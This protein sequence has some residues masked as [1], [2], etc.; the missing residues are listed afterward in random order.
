MLQR[1]L[2]RRPLPPRSMSSNPICGSDRVLCDAAGAPRSLGRSAS[3]PRAEGGHSLGRVRGSALIRITS[4]S[5]REPRPAVGGSGKGASDTGCRSRRID[6]TSFLTRGVVLLA[7]PAPRHRREPAGPQRRTGQRAFRQRSGLDSRPAWDQLR[8]VVEGGCEVVDDPNDLEDLE[9]VC[10]GLTLN[11]TL[12]GKLPVEVLEEAGSG[13]NDASRFAH[14][15]C[16]SVSAIRCRAR[17]R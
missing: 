4:R 13:A 12:G 1:G 15:S 14:R 2:R 3:S 10:R 6:L 11:A 8:Q 7:G 17:C 16:I 9:V 5:Q